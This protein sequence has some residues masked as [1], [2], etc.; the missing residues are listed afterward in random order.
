MEEIKDGAI[1]PPETLLKVLKEAGWN[2]NS[3]HF[4][5]DI[6]TKHDEVILYHVEEKKVIIRNINNIEGK[7]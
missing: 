4:G 2:K 1:I 3:S 5:Y 6:Y 7:G